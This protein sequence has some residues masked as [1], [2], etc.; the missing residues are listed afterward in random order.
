[1]A[2][3]EP[4]LSGAT[5]SRAR[6]LV[7]FVNA[8]NPRHAA[9]LWTALRQLQIAPDDTRDDTPNVAQGGGENAG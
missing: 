1:M 4:A 7:A 2:E 6:G 3:K 8:V 5:F 9:P